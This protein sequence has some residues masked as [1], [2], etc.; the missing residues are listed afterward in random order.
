M[1]NAD[2]A[3][4]RV[5]VEKEDAR[6]IPAFDFS[7]STWS[8]MSTTG[9]SPANQ[10]YVD[11]V[12]IWQD[13]MYAFVQPHDAPHA[14]ALIYRLDLQKKRWGKV[15]GLCSNSLTSYK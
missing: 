8:R 3:R 12:A 13:F 9:T 7:T 14:T 10:T 6:T 4:V 15:G 2:G 11:G 5:Q 1:E